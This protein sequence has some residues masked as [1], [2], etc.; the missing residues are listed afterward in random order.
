MKK[1]ARKVRKYD[2]IVATVYAEGED[3]TSAIYL[4]NGLSPFSR[5][6]GMMPAPP[7]ELIG[8]SGNACDD[9]EQFAAARLIEQLR[10]YADWIAQEHGLPVLDQEALDRLI[11]SKTGKPNNRQPDQRVRTTL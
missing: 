2:G 10:H 8:W 5:R 7:A 1:L 6:R 3:G 9:P 4:V 11:E